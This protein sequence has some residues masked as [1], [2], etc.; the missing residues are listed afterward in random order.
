MNLTNIGV[1]KTKTTKKLIMGFVIVTCLVAVIYIANSPFV[2]AFDPLDPD[3]HDPGNSPGPGQ[4]EPGF[5]IIIS[6]IPFDFCSDIFSDNV[7]NSMR[8]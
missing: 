4:Q 8:L 1:L 2:T 3:P 6:D 5:G 7:L